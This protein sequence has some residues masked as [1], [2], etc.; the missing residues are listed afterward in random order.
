MKCPTHNAELVACETRYGT[1]YACPREGCTVVCWGNE[2]STPADYETRQLRHKCHQEF[3]PLWREN[4]AFKNRKAAYRWLGKVM[5][6]ERGEGHIGMFTK[7]QCEWL[8]REIE[9]LK[10]AVTR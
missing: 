2:T 10:L 5:Q 4:T 9:K 8:L 3:D 7:G 6:T 1:R